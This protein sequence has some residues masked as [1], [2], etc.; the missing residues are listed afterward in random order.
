MIGLRSGEKLPFL[1]DTGAPVTC[2][3]TSLEPRLGKRLGSLTASTF[4]VEHEASVYEA[5][6]LYLGNT[7]L[8]MTSTNVI[9]WDFKTA[10]PAIRKPYVGILGM[11]VLLNYRIQ[12]D[13]AARRLRFLP[14]APSN[15][16]AWG[17]PYPLADVGD[18]CVFIPENL[19]GAPG[20]GSL[21]D[22]GYRGDGFLT[23]ELFQR[24]TNRATPAVEGETRAPN[25]RLGG[26]RYSDINLS[27]ESLSLGDPPRQFNGIG[28]RFLAR[29]LVTFDF[30]NHIMYLKRTSFGP[31]VD[32]DSQAAANAAGKLLDRL[33]RNGR[34]PGWSRRDKFANRTE[35]IDLRYPDFA[36]F[37]H[38]RKKGDSSIYH[39]ELARESATRPWKLKKAWRT[40]TEGRTIE[41]YP[42][43]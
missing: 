39:Y 31:L 18:G 33:K 16:D 19:V 10:P 22:T 8:K 42:V 37:N 12:L 24:W 40:D 30:P 5:P 35:R 7:A 17:A 20:P 9:T 21:V 29:H 3:D 14:A 32:K 38:V 2:L 23:P 28:L 26:E 4:G 41:D 25:A 6:K 43:P 11:H 1:M 34:L 15:K 27:A 13:F 36:A